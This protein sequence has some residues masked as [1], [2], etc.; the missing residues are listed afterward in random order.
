MGILIIDLAP[1]QTES[2]NP[3]NGFSC[4]VTLV[5]DGNHQ[6]NSPIFRSNSN[7]SQ[8]LQMVNDGKQWKLL[9]H[10][11]CI[12]KPQYPHE[13][14]RALVHRIMLIHPQLFPLL[15]PACLDAAETRT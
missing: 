1:G 5:R 7:A 15:F 13:V 11:R 9:G 12:C 2:I 3:P 8:N 14:C 4:I 10:Q 6:L